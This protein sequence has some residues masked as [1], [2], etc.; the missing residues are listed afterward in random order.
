M[1]KIDMQ[2]ATVTINDGGDPGTTVEIGEIYSMSGFDGEAEDRNVTTL[3][4]SAMEWDPG[5][6]DNGNVS[7]ELFRDPSDVGQQACLAARAAQATREFVINYADGSTDTFNAY[8]K[9][10][11][12]N[13]E[14]GGKLQG[15]LN[16][17][18]TGEV[19]EAPAA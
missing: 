16:I 18:I 5:L 4:S 3:A 2:G 1:A 11:S 9:S 19:T 17:K 13:G 7:F 14:R 15:T 10:L 6:Q 8:V 12:K